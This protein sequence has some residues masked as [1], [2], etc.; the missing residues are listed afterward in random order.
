MFFLKCLEGS[1][2]DKVIPLGLAVLLIQSHPSALAADFIITKIDACPYM[3]SDPERKGYIIDILDEVFKRRN[4]VVEYQNNP[5]KRGIK[6]ARA[7]SVDMVLSPTKGEAP[8][9]NYPEEPIGVQYECFI[10]EKDNQWRYKEDLDFKKGRFVVPL[11]W[12]HEKALIS[13]IGHSRYDEAFMMFA[14]NKEYFFRAIEM[15]EKGRVTAIYGDPESLKYKFQVSGKNP[16][17]Y[18]NAGCISSHYLFTGLSPHKDSNSQRLGKIV[19]KGIAELRA[20]GELG[21]ILKKYNI[22]DWD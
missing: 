16:D 18:I 15:L 13:D 3:C 2:L 1:K 8:S 10:T 22:E 14:Y 6:L 11:G 19:D 9:L 12:A 21:K 5:W 17:D 20:E 4:V 7:G